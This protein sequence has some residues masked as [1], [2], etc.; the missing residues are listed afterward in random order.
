MIIPD[1]NLLIYAYDETALLHGTARQWW[2]K[3]LSSNEP[4][5]IALPVAFGFVRLTTRP[6]I[7]L[8][9]LT[10]DEATSTVEIWLEQPHVQVLSPGPQHFHLVCQLLKQIGT[11]G[12]LTT[13]AQLAALTI[14]YQAV[15][16][17]NDTDF[18]RFSGLKIVNPLI[19]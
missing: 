4:V 13:D 1:L 11:A 10:L 6:T 17:T 19:A 16:Y 15:L 7:F 3:V 18:G 8:H 9:P 2:E 14:E 12:N 5:G